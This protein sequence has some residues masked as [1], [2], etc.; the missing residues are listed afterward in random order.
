MS[1]SIPDTH[2]YHNYQAI[3]T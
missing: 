2:H 1:L 3:D